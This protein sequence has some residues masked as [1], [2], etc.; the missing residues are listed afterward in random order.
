M[1]HHDAVV[2]EQLRALAEERVVMIDADM[3]EHADR[4]DAVERSVDVAI[5]L[6]IEP[7][8]VAQPLFRRALVGD[9][10][11]LLRQRDAGHVGAGHFGE[12]EPKPAPAAADIEHALSGLQQ[13]LGGEVPLL[14]ELGV[15]E[16]LVGVFEIGAAVLPV[17][18]EE[19][20]IE[21]SVE[22]VV[23]RDILAR[24]PRAD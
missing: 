1:Q 6:Q 17:G 21:P 8:L 23:M 2:G 18:V 5:V 9:V 19:Q 14:G 16:R 15:V 3:L 22:I 7:G 12:I 13:Q 24:A 20:R 4:D 11:L 10:V